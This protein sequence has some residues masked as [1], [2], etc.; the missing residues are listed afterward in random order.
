MLVHTREL[1]VIRQVDQV[2]MV[3]RQGTQVPKHGPVGGP[4]DPE[5]APLRAHSQMIHPWLLRG[6]PR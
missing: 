6:L 3:L 5:D 2:S 4:N 1:D